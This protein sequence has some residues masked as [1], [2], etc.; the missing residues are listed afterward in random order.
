M[1]ITYG[2][3]RV[4]LQRVIAQP[5][6]RHD[7]LAGEVSVEVLG[8]NF[9]AAYTEGDN[10]AVVAT[11]TMK[12][13]ILRESLACEGDTPEALAEHLARAFLA[14]YPVMEAVR[15]GVRER[16]FDRLSDKLFAGEPEGDHGVATIELHGDEVTER[17]SGR[18]GMWL[19]KVT[20]SS[21][22]RFARD[23]YTTLPERID[24]PLYIRMDADWR[25]DGTPPPSAEVRAELAATFD[26][27]VSE[28]IQHLVHEMG[29]RALARWPQLTE[30]RF[31]AENHTRDPAGDA[32]D[33]ARRLYTDPFPAQGLI[34]LTLQR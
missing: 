28:S 18:H 34:T 27:F 3:L 29:T 31:E 24:R 6:G 21:F 11:D 9:A 32:Q 17:R 30:I 2:K 10:S 14:A 5:S 16:R 26:D 22:T 25:Y 15:V 33:G 8:E 19:L 13:F 20:G 7:L 23:D 1:R 12:N 4:P